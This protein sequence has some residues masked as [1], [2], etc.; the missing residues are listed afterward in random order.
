VVSETESHITASVRPALPVPVNLEYLLAGNEAQRWVDDVG[1][2]GEQ[3][4]P[5]LA[6]LEVREYAGHTRTRFANT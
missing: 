5:T 1:N 6:A 3:L 2:H 4:A